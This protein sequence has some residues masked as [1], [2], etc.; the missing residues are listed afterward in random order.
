MTSSKKEKVV[1]IGS[2]EDNST[3]ILINMSNVNWVNI[4]EN[5]AEFYFNHNTIYKTCRFTGDRK[6]FIKVLIN[7]MENS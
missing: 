4:K 3:D 5:T 1:R 6:D 2:S 7:L